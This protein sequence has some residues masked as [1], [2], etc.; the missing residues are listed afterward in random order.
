MIIDKERERDIY[1][2]IHIYMYVCALLTY[3]NRG[4][5]DWDFRL[6]KTNI[7]DEHRKW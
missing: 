3:K 7:K 6:K 4:K 2:Y 1:I 5:R